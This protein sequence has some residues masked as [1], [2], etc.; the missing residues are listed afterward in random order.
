M[1]RSRVMMPCFPDQ[2]AQTDKRDHNKTF[3]GALL[4]LQSCAINYRLSMIYEVLWSSKWLLHQLQAFTVSRRDQNNAFEGVK[5]GPRRSVWCRRGHMPVP[6]QTHHNIS[7]IT[8]CVVRD[9]SV[10]ANIPNT[11]IGDNTYTVGGAHAT[12]KEA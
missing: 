3:A 6:L 11:T 1:Q 7:D 10:C 9:A 8:T 2:R 4:L 5:C 12:E